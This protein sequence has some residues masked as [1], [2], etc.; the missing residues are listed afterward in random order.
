MSCENCLNHL[1]DGMGEQKGDCEG[2]SETCERFW[3]APEPP[4]EALTNVCRCGELI[5]GGQQ[6]CS[7]CS[8]YRR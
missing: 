4:Q 8:K 5:R 1:R 7:C 6:E 3:K 2:S